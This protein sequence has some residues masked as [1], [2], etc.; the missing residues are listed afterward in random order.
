MS[1]LIAVVRRWRK[2]PCCRGVV[3][4]TAQCV[5][6]G[7]GCPF[8]PTELPS[9]PALGG[10]LPGVLQSKPKAPSPSPIL[11]LEGSLS[12][13]LRGG[14]ACAWPS[15]SHREPPRPLGVER[16]APAVAPPPTSIATGCARVPGTVPPNPFPGAP[17]VSVGQGG[18]F[19]QQGLLAAVEF[20]K[21][22]LLQPLHHSTRAFPASWQAVPSVAALDCSGSC[23]AASILWLPPPPLPVSEFQ[24]GAPGRDDEWRAKVCH[25]GWLPVHCPPTRLVAWGRAGGVLAPSGGQKHGLKYCP[26]PPGPKS[27]ELQ[28]GHAFHN[29]LQHRRFWASP[30]EAEMGRRESTSTGGGGGHGRKQL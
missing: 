15:L 14:D 1:L 27:L 23:L 11:G 17:Q 20:F 8:L 22:G 16:E 13:C 19:A 26:P 30:A 12:P 29:R 24:L 4:D 2:P 28:G 9:S 10:L 25:H 7:G 21:A 3:S 6:G 18:A 5:C